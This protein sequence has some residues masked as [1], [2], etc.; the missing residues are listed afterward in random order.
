[1]RQADGW[2]G[3]AFEIRDG[4][5]F[6]AFFNT[7]GQL[8][9]APK[10]GSKDGYALLVTN[11]AEE[12]ANARAWILRDGSAGF[13]GNVSVAGRL[14]NAELDT[15]LAKMNE[16]LGEAKELIAQANSVIAHL[17][18]QNEMLTQKIAKLEKSSLT[19][20]VDNIEQLAKEAQKSETFFEKFCGFSIF[21]EHHSSPTIEVVTILG[22]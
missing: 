7:D 9:L 3:R 17:K 10:I 20:F 2:A 11:S 16:E 21:F 8:V 5:I 13:N 19:P 15:K 22:E 14:V 1:M 12:G 18:D 6:R 4:V